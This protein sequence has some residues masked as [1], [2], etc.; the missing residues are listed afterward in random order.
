VGKGYRRGLRHIVNMGRRARE[1]TLKGFPL[2][3]VLGGKRGVIEKRGRTVCVD[4]IAREEGTGRGGVRGSL[5]KWEKTCG[6]RGGTERGEKKKKKKRTGCAAV[7]R[8]EEGIREDGGR[9]S[10]KEP[11]SDLYRMYQGVTIPKPA[12]DDSGSG[13]KLQA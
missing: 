9:V 6:V 3:E 2:D 5:L 12:Q 11:R 8:G 10:E 13:E 1:N 7:D 4:R